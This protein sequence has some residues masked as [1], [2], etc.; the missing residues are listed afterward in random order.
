MVQNDSIGQRSR[1]RGVL[2]FSLSRFPHFVLRKNSIFEKGTPSYYFFTIFLEE[3]L[4]RI[5]MVQREGRE[6]S[7]SP[8][9]RVMEFQASRQMKTELLVQ[10]D[11]LA[12]TNALVFVWPPVSPLGS[13]HRHPTSSEEA[14]SNHFPLIEHIIV[15]AP[16]YVQI[17]VPLPNNAAR[18]QS[19][20][21][22]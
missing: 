22:V 6:G 18:A 10:M 4:F 12:T 5:G 1:T 15:D 21:S 3:C 2:Y 9:C 7:V 8:Y 19:S 14:R 11:G 20:S 17:L 13:G 16:D